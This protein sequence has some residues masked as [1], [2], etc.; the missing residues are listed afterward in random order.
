MCFIA[1]DIAVHRWA[2]WETNKSAD[3]SRKNNPGTED[4]RIEKVL[5]LF[6]ARNDCDKTFKFLRLNSYVFYRYAYLYNNEEFDRTQAFLRDETKKL[7]EYEMKIKNYHDLAGRIPIE[8][9]R[10]I[11]VGFFEVSC[12][13]FVRIV[14]ENVERFKGLLIDHLVDKYQNTTKK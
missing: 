7:K 2:A 6:I 8:V 12:A 4:G 9:E 11:F 10:T 5:I 3:R 14:V 13:P 1:T